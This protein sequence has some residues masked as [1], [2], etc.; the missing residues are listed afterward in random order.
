MLTHQYRLFDE[1]NLLYAPI[2]GAG[3]DYHGHVPR[4]TAD[5]IMHRAARIMTEYEDLKR[6]LSE[7]LAQVEKR[8]IK[9]AQNAKDSLEYMKQTLKKREYRKLDFEKIPE[10]GRCS[11]KKDKKD[12]ARYGKF[13]QVPVRVGRGYSSIPRR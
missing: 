3:D 8:L 7:D 6:D 4:Q 13:D 11:T 5:H 10:Q 1:Y 12:R 9:P 2:V